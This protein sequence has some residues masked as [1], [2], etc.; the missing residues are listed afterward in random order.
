MLVSILVS[1]TNCLIVFQIN[2]EILNRY[3][4]DVSQCT[5]KPFSRDPKDANWVVFDEERT[6]LLDEENPIAY[7]F[8][9]V[10]CKSTNGD[11]L[12]RDVHKQI[13]P[14]TNLNGKPFPKKGPDEMNVALII[15]ESTSRLNWIR[16]CPEVHEYIT[17][18]LGGIVF[19]GMN[20]LADN[21]SPNL[22][23]MATG[24]DVATDWKKL[25][26]SAVDN[27]G[28]IWKDAEKEG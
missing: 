12:Y 21:T 27:L 2:A 13:I 3:Y 14:K 9:V 28:W 15:L 23:A 6:L 10:Y 24:K 25:L 16:Q 18:S 5:Y 22:Y 26:F 7:E 4:H 1:K 11:L 17:N 8:I 19:N 20:K